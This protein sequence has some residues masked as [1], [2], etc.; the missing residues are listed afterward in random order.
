VYLG[1]ASALVY[2]Q[3]SAE[4]VKDIRIESDPPGA[5]VEMLVGTKREPV[6]Q[7]PLTYRAEFHSEISV[8]RFS[9][10]K[11]GYVPREFEVTGKDDRVMVRLQERSFTTSPA[12]HSDPALQ[13]LQEQLVAP[14]EKVVREAL[15]KQEPFEVDLAREIQVQ[16]IDGDAYLVVPLAVG[17][18]PVNYRQ[19]GAGNAQAFLADLWNQL[20]DGFA[21]P[22]VQVERKV[23]G[24]KGIVL[25]VD[26]SRVQSGFGVGVRVESNVEMECQPG[27]KTQAV[28]DLCATR[29]MGQT[30]N[31]QTHN[32]EST[33]RLECVGG[34]VT[35]QVFDP[36]ADR[37]P[38]TKTTLVADP[39][40]T[41]GQAKS[42]ARYVGSLRAFGTA[43]HAKDVYGR[44]GAVL[45]DNNGGVLARQG[46]L[47]TS[48]VPPE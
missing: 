23:E 16:R 12:K 14:T 22:L 2:G 20:G 45:T 4:V 39:K 3:L 6:G 19:V 29:K 44:I 5:I 7:T 24:L 31:A 41:F 47:P 21:M 28:F 34:M 9:A 37:V 1:L 35:K 36:C 32:W 8:L 27:T 40:V 15:R 33:G 30:Y 43:A 17:H 11:P 18:A 10:R 26:Y 38:V 13:K 25:D 46:D 42:K 48:L